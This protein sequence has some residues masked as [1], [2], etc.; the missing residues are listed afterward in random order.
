MM[1]QEIDLR[2]YLVAVMRHGRLIIICIV[3]LA[4]VGAASSAL[5]TLNQRASA[6]VLVIP[7]SSQITLDP[8]FQTTNGSNVSNPTAARQALI[9]LASSH[10]VAEQVIKDLGDTGLSIDTLSQQVSVTSSSDL[11]QITVSNSDPAKALKL[12]EAWGKAYERLV[13]DIYGRSQSQTEL[14]ASTI[15]ASQQ[16]YDVAQTALETFLSDGQSVRVEGQITSLTEMLSGSRQAQLLLYTDYLTRTRQ[17]DLILQD[18]QTLQDQMST[19]ATSS[20]ADS[21]AALLLRART[22][23]SDAPSFQ[24][25]AGDI[26]SAQVSSRD[27]L[28]A[29]DQLI[30]VLSRRRDQLSARSE[31]IAATI[32]G[33]AAPSGTAA[34][35][36]QRYSDQLAT[37]M[38]T[39]EQL[40]ARQALLT[41]QRDIARDTLILLQR[42]ND[43]QEAGR[44]SPPIE[45][46]FI[47]ANIEPRSSIIAQPI[48]RG[49]IAGVVGLI[50][51]ALLAILFDVVVPALRRLNLREPAQPT[52]RNDPAAD[53]PVPG[54]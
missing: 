47:S 40:Q 18:A 1:E 42:K 39:Y 21:F 23:D 32:A 6:D 22:V 35:S 30:A 24:L 26:T 49:V 17:L 37:L 7:S 9:N 13:A 28:T 3:A 12:A 20:F 31:E 54:D 41:Q 46:R 15:V 16:R 44:S 52:T 48:Q 45:V 8:R 43:E 2:P 33:N 50:L 29:L 51:G 10:L 14:L 27:L 38:S 5:T 36:Q 4:L 53:R 11:L 19:Q 25:S 34:T